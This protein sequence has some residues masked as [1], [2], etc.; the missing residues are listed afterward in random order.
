M[1]AKIIFPPNPMLDG[2]KAVF[3]PSEKLLKQYGFKDIPE[4]ELAQAVLD[5][6]HPPLRYS[7]IKMIEILGNDWEQCKKILEEQ[8][9]IDAFIVEDTIADNDMRFDIFLKQVKKCLGE[10]I[11][12]CRI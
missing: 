4:T 5:L 8:N 2:N 3:N 7:K 10:K 11:N 12:I 1:F 9:L 6:V